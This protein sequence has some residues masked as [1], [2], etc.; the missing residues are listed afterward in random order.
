MTQ[1]LKFSFMGSLLTETAIPG[2][3]CDEDMLVK[4]TLHTTSPGFYV[5]VFPE[6]RDITDAPGTFF[7]SLV[8]AE[9]WVSEQVLVFQQ[10]TKKALVA[11]HYR[12]DPP[13]YTEL[14][15]GHIR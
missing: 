8:D 2:T 12:T 3:Y 4:V 11:W 10:K 5:E 15:Q 13:S 6:H 7:A 1:I 14:T 9:A